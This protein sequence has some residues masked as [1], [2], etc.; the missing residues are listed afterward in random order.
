V[1][2]VDGAAVGV[3]SKV[4]GAM[5]RSRLVLETARG[6]VLIPLVPEICTTIDPAAKRIVIAPPEGLLELNVR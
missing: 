1:Q 6:E 4:E 5:G 2:T 3:V